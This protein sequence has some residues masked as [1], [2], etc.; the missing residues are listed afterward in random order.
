[1]AYVDSPLP[2]QQIIS[3]L[4]LLEH[5]EGGYFIETNRQEHQVP[6]PFVDGA[7]RDL[8]TSIYYF[9]THDRPKGYIHMNKS[10]TY[11][12]L[13]HG[14]A[15]YTLIHPG[16][17]AKVERVVMGADVSK[18]E[19][20]MLLVGTGVWK[21]SRLLDEDIKTK[22]PERVGCLITEVVVPGFAW[23][24]HKYLTPP[25]LK[26]LLEGVPNSEHWIQEL[27]QYVKPE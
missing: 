12:V 20:R 8:A 19:L 16:S 18:G 2:A 3:D 7:P 9:L 1:M 26:P 4:K 15:E 14:R 11:H 25:E 22:D 17:P 27:Q 5:P 10:V 23:E 21:M 24:D 6:S 13:H